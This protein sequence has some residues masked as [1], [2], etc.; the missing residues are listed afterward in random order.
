MVLTYG[1]VCIR[2]YNRKQVKLKPNV[3]YKRARVKQQYSH[4]STLSS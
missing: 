1:I 3:K 2:D 4:E